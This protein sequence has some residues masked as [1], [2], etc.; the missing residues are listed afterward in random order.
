MSLRSIPSF[1]ALAFVAFA[2]QS[3]QPAS[4]YVGQDD[5]EIKS[6]SFED[7][8]ALLAG[9]GMGLAKAAELNGYPGPAH[10]LELSDSLG[11][12]AEQRSQTEALFTSMESHAQSLGRALVQEE[13]KLDNL[14]ATKSVTPEL[15]SRSLAEIGSLQARGRGAHLQAHLSQI[16]ILTP[17]QVALYARLRGYAEPATPSHTG[18]KH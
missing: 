8:A 9:K 5:R 16:E 4:P 18:H 1:I 11:F 12:T 15:L 3:A 14:F 2:V 6:L 13:R 10:V 7:T 17:E